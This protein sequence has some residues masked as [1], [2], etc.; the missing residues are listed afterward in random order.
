MMKEVNFA[1][2]LDQFLFSLMNSLGLK[3]MGRIQRGKGL[4]QLN[5]LTFSVE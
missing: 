5:V 4:L 3:T 2:F 1:E